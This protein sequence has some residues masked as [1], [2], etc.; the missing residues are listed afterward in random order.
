MGAERFDV[1]RFGAMCAYTLDGEGLGRLQ[2]ETFSA[3]WANVVFRGF[4]THPGYA[5]G[6]MVNAIKVAAD[7]I[8]RL[9]KDR[10]SPETTSSREGYVH[11]NVIEGGVAEARVRFIV[12]DFA[13]PKLAEMEAYLDKLAGETTQSWPG[14]S[15]E[16]QVVESY[17][18]MKEV[19]DRYPQV[20]ENARE[21]IRRAGVELKETLIR[22]GT[23]GSRLSYMGLPTPNLFTGQENLHSKI[24]WVSAQD[25]EKSVEVI[26]HLSR[27]W[28]ERA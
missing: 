12:R 5:K 11:P 2:I 6:S 10:L 22:G 20:V 7:F 26:V 14:S 21:A 24:E 27:V 23:D 13:T 17:R 28:E 4:N 3:D 8:N 16:V 19:L 15:H 18:N 9:P 25:M 1:K